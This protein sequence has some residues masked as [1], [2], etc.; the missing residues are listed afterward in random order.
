MKGMYT[1]AGKIAG[2]TVAK[3]LAYITVASTRVLELVG[4]SVTDE[5]NPTN[6]QMQIMLANIS[7]LG[8]PSGYTAITPTK[9]ED[10]DQAATTTVNF[11][12]GGGTTNEP[13]TYGVIRFQEGANI[14]NGFIHDPQIDARHK[15]GPGVI[16]GIKLVTTPGASTDF[17]VR[18]TFIEHG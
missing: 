13:T 11:N 5:S 18:I 17:D 16:F 10:G 15:F 12:Q 7:V 1:A 9:H 6:Y 14:L 8:S 2:I 3:T 4:F